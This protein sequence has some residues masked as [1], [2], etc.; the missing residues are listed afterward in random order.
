MSAST[1]ASIWERHPG[2]IW[3]NRQA[4]D[5]VRIRAALLKP[6]FPTLLDVA[7]TFGPDRLATEWTVLWNDPYTDTRRA[8]PAVERILTNIRRGYE[9]ARS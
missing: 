9:Q 5:A 6:N 3:S 2:L 1:R 8:A 4:D 7:V